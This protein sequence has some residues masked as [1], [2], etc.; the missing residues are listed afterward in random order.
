MIPPPD[1]PLI[2][3]LDVSDLDRA[4]TLAAEL[5]G[6][7][8]ML[9]VGLELFWAH[10]PEAVRRIARHAPVFVDAKLHDIP[11]TVERAA[12]N[13]ARLGVAM[14]NVHSLGGEAMMRAAVDGAV[15]GA[16][17]RAQRASWSRA[18][19]S[20][21][22]GRCAERSSVWWFPASAPRDP[23]G[24]TRCASSRPRRRSRR[25]PTT[26]SWAVP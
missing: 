5:T 2:V 20:R 22:C 7:A 18:R 26:S 3:A 23:T 11:T 16:E 1:N 17:R 10:G 8:G 19:T 9:K 6:R 4:E 15:R 13:I 21:R 12:A 14:M 25:A 24:T